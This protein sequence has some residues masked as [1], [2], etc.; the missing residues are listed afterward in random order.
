MGIWY[1][2]VKDKRICRRKWTGSIAFVPN[3]KQKG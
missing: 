2:P 1:N 3:M